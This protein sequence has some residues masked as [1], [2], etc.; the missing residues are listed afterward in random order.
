MEFDSRDARRKPRCDQKRPKKAPIAAHAPD[1]SL[2]FTGIIGPTP[3][4]AI[5]T[6]TAPHSGPNHQNHMR[7]KN[8]H[9]FRNLRTYTCKFSPVSCHAKCFSAAVNESTVQ[10]K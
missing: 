9:F 8:G 2:F 3:C 7:Q 6:T 5:A 1:G 10:K 4:I